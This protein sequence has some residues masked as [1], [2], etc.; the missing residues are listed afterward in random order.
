MSALYNL[1]LNPVEDTGYGGREDD[2]IQLF[3]Q[4]YQ[5]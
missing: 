4:R 1:Q 3:S 5:G 2:S